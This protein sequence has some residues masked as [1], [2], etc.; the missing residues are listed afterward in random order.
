MGETRKLA[1]ILVA[2][3]ARPRVSTLR[4]VFRWEEN[5]REQQN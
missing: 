3:A 2:A 5:Q 4:A 1:A